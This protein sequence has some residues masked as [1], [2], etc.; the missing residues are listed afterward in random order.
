M[1]DQAEKLI[2]PY[3]TNVVCSGSISR[4]RSI[5]GG[6]N[7]GIR[8]VQQWHSVGTTVAFGGYNS[9]IWQRLRLLFSFVATHHMGTS[10]DIS[11]VKVGQQIGSLQP[12]EV[13][14]LSG[15]TLRNLICLVGRQVHPSFHRTDRMV[16]HCCNDSLVRGVTFF[17]LLLILLLF[18]CYFFVLLLSYNH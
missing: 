1:A 16:H 9:G 6:Y 11:T 2:V 4:G 7:I 17:P 18:L 8:W 14:Y 13:Q 3:L 5:A 12:P 15:H 10:T